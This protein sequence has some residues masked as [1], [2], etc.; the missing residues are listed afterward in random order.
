[1]DEHSQGGPKITYFELYGAKQLAVSMLS[2]AAWTLASDPELKTEEG[3]LTHDWVA[4]GNIGALSFARCIDILGLD[5]ADR[6]RDLILENPARVS[7]QLES[8]VKSIRQE[9]VVRN[10]R[11]EGAD[12]GGDIFAK[13]LDLQD[14]PKWGATLDEASIAPPSSSEGCMARDP[15][16]EMRGG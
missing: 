4:K 1:M 9:A 14:M 8:A 13:G 3:A 2:E 7:K 16:L 15:A 5:I 11:Q 6:L 10:I 12:P